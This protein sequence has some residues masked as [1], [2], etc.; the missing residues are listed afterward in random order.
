MHMHEHTDTYM[1]VNTDTHRRTQ[2]MHTLADTQVY[3]HTCRHT[4]TCW[5]THADTHR[6]PRTHVLEHTCR[7][8]PTCWYTHA[9]TRAHDQAQASPYIPPLSALPC[10]MLGPLILPLCDCHTSLNLRVTCILFVL[11]CYLI[12]TLHWSIVGLPR[13]HYW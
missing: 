10:A 6:R 11:F 13:R 7:H 4:P 3:A 8:T 1:Q 5:Y 2:N 9:D 12:L